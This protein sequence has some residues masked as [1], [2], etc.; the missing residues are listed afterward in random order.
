MMN[1][2]MPFSAMQTAVDIV[3]ASPHP[4]NKIAATLVCADGQAISR[5]NA[6]PAAIA[7][8]LGTE[9]RI[10]NSSGTIHAE[11][12]CILAANGATQGAA[13]FVTD[14]PCPNCVKNMAE[15][16]I[17]ALYID[18]KGFDKDFSQRRGDDFRAM[19]LKVAEKA[20]ISVYIVYRKNQRIETLQEPTTDYQP[21]EE[22]PILIEELKDAPPLLSSTP[23]NKGCKPFAS[24]VATNVQ[25]RSFLMIAEAHPVIGY[26]SE[27]IE[28][29]EGKYTFILEP[30]NRLIMGAARRGLNID[31]AQLYSSRVP[32]ARE[33][34]NMIGSGLDTLQI[35][36]LQDSR[37]AHGLDA[38]RILTDAKIL[39]VQQ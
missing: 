14:P 12:A 22:N 21:A 16:G 27:T 6:W 17:T 9:V 37:D 19:S 11:T 5:T 18:H 7:S 34:I 3:G 1:Q 35:G 33:L 26:T 30:V 29:P 38:L 2:N 13:L 23:Y 25:G 31:P 8:T 36:N 28:N 15:A 39:N 24:A 20:G 32:T 10:G 4:S